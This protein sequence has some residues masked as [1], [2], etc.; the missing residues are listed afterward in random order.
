M[1]DGENKVVG[2]VEEIKKQEAIAE[3]SRLKIEKLKEKEAK[4][5][6]RIAD[7]VGFFEVDVTDEAL[8]QMFTELI[9]SIKTPST[10]SATDH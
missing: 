10:A 7:K 5:M 1:Q 3:Q 4:R 2:I 9:T 6:V 8:T